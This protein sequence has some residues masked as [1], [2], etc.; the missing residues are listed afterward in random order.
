MKYKIKAEKS[1]LIYETNNKRI[2]LSRFAYF[3]KLY[4]L[5]DKKENV[6]LWTDEKLT[7]FRN[8]KMKLLN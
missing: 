4:S 3:S 8:N 7:K 2:A 1:G 5:G 6:E